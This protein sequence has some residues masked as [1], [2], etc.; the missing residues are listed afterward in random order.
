MMAN[1]KW[2]PG[3]DTENGHQIETR[4]ISGIWIIANNNV[5]SQQEKQQ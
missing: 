3:W 2:S 1:Y 5:L 4:E